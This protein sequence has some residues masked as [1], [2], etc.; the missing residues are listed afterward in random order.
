MLVL[1]PQNLQTTDMEPSID[2]ILSSLLLLFGD[3][4]TSDTFKHAEEYNFDWNKSNLT[5]DPWGTS[6]TWQTVPHDEKAHN[7]YFSVW[8]SYT[9]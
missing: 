8:S 9:I 4:M 1:S 5:G 2:S 7:I 3:S 6:A